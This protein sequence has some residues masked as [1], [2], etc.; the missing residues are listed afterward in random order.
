[1]KTKDEK[2]I[3]KEIEE[4]HRLDTKNSKKREKKNSNSSFKNLKSSISFKPSSNS[5]KNL[6]KRLSQLTPKETTTTLNSITNTNK[7]RVK[8]KKNITVI[9]VECWKEYNLEQV[10][11]EN[12]D[13]IVEDIDDDG[14]KKDKKGK[15]KKKKKKNNEENNN[16]NNK[17]ENISCTCLII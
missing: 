4:Q 3:S 12:F 15:K 11:E 10:A 13:N 6:N 7:K 17:K 16:N 2:N 9:D 1:M 8:F 14:N 5:K